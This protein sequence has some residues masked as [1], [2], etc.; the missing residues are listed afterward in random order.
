MRNAQTIICFILLICCT[1][2]LRAQRPVVPPDYQRVPVIISKEPGGNA[3]TWGTDIGPS[4]SRTQTFTT[5]AMGS[6]PN[7][8]SSVRTEQN[9]VFTRANGEMAFIHRNAP[10]VWGGGS[11]DLRY[12]CSTDAGQTWNFGNGPLNS[13]L[14]TPARYP[15][16][17][18][19]T[20]A[21]GN[22]RPIW[23][24]AALGTSSWDGHHN[25]VVCNYCTNP[26]SGTESL[27]FVGS[28]A[29]LP[30][31]LSEGLS[32]E[33]WV[34]S[35]K[36]NGTSVTDSVMVFKA[37]YSPNCEAPWAL[38]AVLSGNFNSGSTGK[39][40]IGPNMAFS[41]DG[42]TAYIVI[43]GDLAGGI[44]SILTPIVHKSTNAGATWSAPHEVDLS[45]IQ[46]IRDSLQSLWGQQ[47]NAGGVIP[48]SSGHY[49]C[50][51]DYDVTVDKDGN[52]HIF[53]L[54]ASATVLDADSIV[55]PG[56]YGLWPGLAKLM[57]DIYTP[58]GGTSWNARYIAPGYAF[59]GDFGTSNPVTLDN[60]CQISRDTSGEHIFF[61]WVDQ[62]TTG[63]FGLADLV[64]PNLRIAGVR[65]ADSNQTCWYRISDAD[66]VWGGRV[67]APTMSPEVYIDGNEYSLPIVV[68]ELST[69]DPLQQVNYFYF[70]DGA[71]IDNQ[72]FLP[73][74]ALNLAA[75]W[76]GC[77]VVG[78]DD[79]L[80]STGLLN[81]EAFWPQPA[82]A[83]ARLRFELAHFAEFS[84]ELFD[85]SGR[86]MRTVSEQ[87]MDS[88]F[89]EVKLSTAGLP[90]G[91]Y[92]L[93]L[94][95][96]E[97]GGNYQTIN[98]RLVV[99]H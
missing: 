21:N 18:L 36:W 32:G 65:V 52:L 96:V 81:L 27:D 68:P 7:I 16:M 58:D 64:T 98:Q 22:T 20:D 4:G 50:T 3:G 46:F 92:L 9:Q 76:P 13:T 33:F 44:D 24:A 89:H 71:R 23:N 73:P 60:F 85:L 28:G 82:D 2:G 26:S 87:V 75:P 54:L 45:G 40:A 97:D 5:P 59:R 14:G 35:L 78:T 30:S 10:F 31:G 43:M 38:H 93:R 88:G 72:A 83:T 19:H 48:V 86:K 57:V 29:Y 34:S 39:V 69:G 67:I 53:N 15:Q 70:G 94:K 61:S 95:A 74:S 12:D 6:G 51:G 1:Q 25:G 42:N 56:A 63:Q 80:E 47:S 77:L 91:I 99:Q 62:D 17:I 11:G 84:L 55:Q 66:L 49:T 79:P 8:F 90:N 37:N 41:P